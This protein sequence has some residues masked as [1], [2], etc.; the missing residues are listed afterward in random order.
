M[1]LARANVLPELSRKVTFIQLT[2]LSALTAEPVQT[3]VLP[4]QSLLV[5]KIK[6]HL[7]PAQTLAFF[8]L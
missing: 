8:I 1:A 7:L 6:Q 4:E 2:L 5:N 3:L